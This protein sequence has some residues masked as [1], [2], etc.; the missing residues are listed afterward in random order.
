MRQRLAVIASLA[1]VATALAAAG[2]QQAAPR[3]V[4]DGAYT[5]EQAKRGEA[6]YKETCEACHGAKLTGGDLAPPLTDRDFI[7]AWRGLA[8]SDL[9]DK[10]SMTMPSNEPGKLTPRQAADVLAFVLSVNRYP[11]GTTEL[12]NEASQLKELRMVAPP[13]P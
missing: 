1:M 10:I 3:T 11:A 9:F 5:T 8:V 13:Q 6:I 4:L 7:A 2:A 12:P